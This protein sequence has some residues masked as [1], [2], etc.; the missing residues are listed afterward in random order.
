MSGNYVTERGAG[1][2]TCTGAELIASRALVDEF[3]TGDDRKVLSFLVRCFHDPKLFAVDS[4]RF[5][6]NLN[7]SDVVQSM[8]RLVR[9]GYIREDKLRSCER[10]TL[11]RLDLKGG[12]A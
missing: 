9:H 12:A 11:Y 5:A 2:N 10:V 4:V 6:I 1:V 3:L 8:N 7:R